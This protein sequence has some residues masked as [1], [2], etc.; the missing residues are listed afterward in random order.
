MKKYFLAFIAVAILGACS[1]DDNGS[2]AINQNNLLGKWYLKG[3]T[4]N[5]GAFESYN[6]ECATSKDFQE[7][8]SDGVLDFIGYD[9]E[10]EVSDTDMSA[11]EL[12]GNI[13]TISNTQFD[14]LVYSYEYIVKSISSEEL[15]L[16][17]TVNTPE[18][19]MTYVVYATRH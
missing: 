1:S 3:G 14:P 16:E 7:F 2:N 10:C 17:Q 5:G 6:H 11:W 15:I 12:N 19:E 13:L 8:H 9:V 4:T 18:G